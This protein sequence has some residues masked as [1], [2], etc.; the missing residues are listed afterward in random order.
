MIPQMRDGGRTH[1]QPLLAL[2]WAMKETHPSHPH[3]WFYFLFSFLDPKRVL[4]AT[5]TVYTLPFTRSTSSYSS[6]AQGPCSW[7]QTHQESSPTL[8]GKQAASRRSWELLSFQRES[9]PNSYFYSRLYRKP[10]LQLPSLLFQEG[11]FDFHTCLPFSR[12]LVS[13]PQSYARSSPEFIA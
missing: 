5:T 7:W 8:L 2:L 3:S 10:S 11:V 6:E 12:F 13:L 1:K 4:L 9:I